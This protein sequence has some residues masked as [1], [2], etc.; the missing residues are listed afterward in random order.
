MLTKHLFYCLFFTLIGFYAEAQKIYYFSGSDWCAPC[1]QLKKT[2]IDQPDFQQLLKNQKIDFEVVDFPQRQKGIT[3]EVKYYRDSL[4]KVMNPKGLFPLLVLKTNGNEHKIL[5]HKKDRKV[6]F[7]QIKAYSI[8]TV[9]TTQ[10]LEVMGSFF[11]LKLPKEFSFLHDSTIHFVK[12][13]VQEF[14]SW[15]SLSYT[16]Q[17]N[18]NA[19]GSSVKVSKRYFNFIKTVQLFGEITGGAFDVTAQPLIRIWDWKR[20]IVPHDSLIA[21]KIQLVNHQSILLDSIEQSVLLKDSRMEIGFGGCGKG[22]VADEVI[23]YWKA[24]GVRSGVV[25]AGGDLY[26]LGKKNNAP[27]SVSLKNPFDNESF[28]YE[29]NIS[30]Y[31]AVTSGTYERFFMQDSV[32]LSHFIHPKTGRPVD[33]NLVSVTV[34]GASAFLC[35]ALATAVFVLGAEQGMDLVSQLKCEVIVLKKDGTV[36]KSKGIQDL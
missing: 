1:V 9:Y 7:D 30:D 16:S 6:L 15:D 20:G 19:G 34:L 25:N 21:K 36:I 28:L 8:T 14:S 4:A 24:H 17:I 11:E 35:D 18:K 27:W 29:L 31:A 23:K 2:V 13:L 33:D 12:D 26:V 3:K 10:R 32:K 5:N 22:Y